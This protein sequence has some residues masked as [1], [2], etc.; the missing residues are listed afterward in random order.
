V[1][2]R[3][4]EVGAAVRLLRRERGLTQRQL[5]EKAEVSKST[6]TLLETGRGNTTLESLLKIARALD[7][8]VVLR[9]AP[10]YVLQPKPP[11]E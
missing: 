3:E 6:V 10:T 1:P 5:A 9:S 11:L 2:S 7:A 4:Q 8:E